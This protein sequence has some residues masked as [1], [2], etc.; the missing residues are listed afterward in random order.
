[1]LRYLFA[2]R[3]GIG[4]GT[5]VLLYLALVAAPLILARLTGTASGSAV[6]EL[7]IGMGLAAFAIFLAEFWLGG[8]S[9][10][11]ATRG[12]LDVYL[13]A[14]R[15]AGIGAF[16]LMSGHILL[17]GDP[18]SPL[19]P[20]TAAAAGLVVIGLILKKRLL[21]YELWRIMHGVAAA[22]VA[23]GGLAHALRDGRYSG[24]PLLAAF[25]GVL[26]LTAVGTL[27]WTHFGPL[28]WRRAGRYAVVAVRPVAR[29]QWTVE[30]EPVDGR[31]L[32][33]YAG[34]YAFLAVE[35][36]P[37]PTIGH[38][39]SF[40]SAPSDRPRIAFTVSENGDFTGRIGTLQPGTIVRLDGPYGHLSPDHYRGPA[41]RG[42]GLVLIGGGV[43]F[44]PLMSILR[45]WR[46]RGAREPVLAFYAVQTYEDILWADEIN[47]LVRQHGATIRV[48]LSQPDP[49]WAGST[50][51]LD[52]EYLRHYL[53]VPGRDQY[54][55]FICGSTRLNDAVLNSLAELRCA[56]PHRVHV[57]NFAVYD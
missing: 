37:F 29:A 54:L 5:F 17:L 41:E 52:T 34:Q 39:F 51:R 56:S 14:H 45:E 7:G 2:V 21:R 53:A 3:G 40:S 4:P 44:A 19:G 42:R 20:L 43:G 27:L 47:Q 30:L 46:A 36:A 25:W 11:R 23:F 50:G 16:A 49:A 1:M 18:P 26:A 28:R 55:Y 9:A 24:A 22:L 33:F 8:R 57:E 32:D 31:A 48:V 6:R 10:V 15:S 35:G 38:P 12:G 13:W